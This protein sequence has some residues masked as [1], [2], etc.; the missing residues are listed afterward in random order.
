M[1]K[2][3]IDGATSATAGELLRILIHHPDV[4]II[5]LTD[6]TPGSAGR[7]ADA[8][9]HGLT[10][11]TELAVTAPGDAPA[12]RADV[13]FLCGA[14]PS[15]APGNWPSQLRVVDVTGRYVDGSWGFVTGLCELNRKALVR[16]ATRA[17]VPTAGVQA[18]ALAL[19]PLAKHLL[20]NGHIEAALT[21]AA[22]DAQAVLPVLTDCLTALQRSFGADM[23]IGAPATGTGRALHATVALDCALRAD[24]LAAM[25]HQFYDDHNFTFIVDAPAVDADVVNTNK[26]LL[27]L[28]KPSAGKLAVNTVLDARI[29]GGAGTAVHCMNLLFGLHE[30]TGLA[31]KALG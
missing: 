24:D 13:L 12:G 22:A 27:C 8:V 2:V 7:R 11:D 10:G 19:L 28:Q 23:T 6:A 1:I 30:R 14:E 31:L 5:A 17:S 3:A 25:Y 16:G 21:G 29:K 15:W 20:L 26:C 9:H 4:E 18:V